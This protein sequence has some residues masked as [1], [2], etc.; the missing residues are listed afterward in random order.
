MGIAA[1]LSQHPLF[2]DVDGPTLARLAENFERRSFRA[3]EVVTREGD[4]ADCFFLVESGR[5][6]VSKS[7]DVV[8][9][10]PGAHFGE[11]GMLLEAP[12]TATV[13]AATDCE[14]LVL[15]VAA[16]DAALVDAPYPAAMFLR[17]LA[18][19]LA[20]RLRSTT[21]ELTMLKAQAA[22]AATSRCGQ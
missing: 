1:T 8:E 4:P 21:D 7:A 22:H 19:S 3:G 14:V 9:L 12:R 5:V 13:S 10:G 18:I 20:D 11:L 2:A 17:A 6:K 15:S 16:L